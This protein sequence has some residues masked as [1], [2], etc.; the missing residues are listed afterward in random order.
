MIS[1]GSRSI[2]SQRQ[3][4]NSGLWPSGGLAML[5]SLSGPVKRSAYHFLCLAAEPAFPGLPDDLARNVV[6]QPLRHF[7]EFLDRPDAS[8]LVKLAQRRL[9]GVLVLVDA[10]LRHLPGMRG[11]DMLR[12]TAPLADEHATLAIDHHDPDAGTI[13]KR[14]VAAHAGA[15]R[16]TEWR[17]AYRRP[18]MT[19]F[20]TRYPRFAFFSS[21]S[22]GLPPP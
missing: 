13:W 1:A 14:F 18:K 2:S 6:A 16:N 17:I 8:L 4:T 3:S 11:V 22:P 20:A 19:L 10:A 21:I 7:A 9:V 12:P 5:I 15:N